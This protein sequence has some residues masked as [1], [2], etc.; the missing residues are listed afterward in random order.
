M[1]KLLFICILLSALLSGCTY[2]FKLDDLDEGNKLYIS[3]VAGDSPRTYINVEMAQAVN[4]EKSK[5]T[6]LS[7]LESIELTINGTGTELSLRERI[8]VDEES[9]YFLDRTNDLNLWYT[10]KPVKPG[11]V[12]ELKVRAKGMQ[13]VKAQT[14]VPEKLSIKNLKRTIVETKDNFMD[15]HIDYEVT[16]DNIASDGYYG[17]SI[18]LEENRSYSHIS[19]D[20]QDIHSQT[21]TM[22]I[23]PHDYSAVSNLIGEDIGAD[24]WFETYLDESTNTFTYWSNKR[25]SMIE[26]KFLKGNTLYFSTDLYD[27]FFSEETEMEGIYSSFSCKYRMKVIVYRVSPELYRYAK[28]QYM[29]DNNYL[30]EAGLTPANFSYS[31]IDGGFGVLC[32]ITSCESDWM[33]LSD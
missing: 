25:I 29:I 15:S 7:S 26:G 5:E 19:E 28:S 11:D 4:S 8:P 23:S 27:D 33:S 21:D 20:Y 2:N 18:L 1:K 6:I 10:D 13:P 22:Y 17:V 3:C 31:N 30:S 32:S 24:R 16:L 12:L 14:A 9:M